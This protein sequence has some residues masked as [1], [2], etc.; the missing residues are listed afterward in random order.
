MVELRIQE[1]Q[2]LLGIGKSGGKAS[3][4]Q[5]I[6]VCSLPDTAVMRNALTLQEKT[7]L[8]IYA[9]TQ[10]VIKLTEEGKLYAV[11]GLPERK[12]GVA[13]IEM[14]GTADLN[15]AAK[16]A[17]LQD[18]FIQIALGWLIRKKWAIYFSQ[19]NTVNIFEEQLQVGTIAEGSDE[20]L[21]K[22]LA[23]NEQTS[24][25]ELTK[26][27]K[28]EA[29]LLKKRK[30]VTIEPKTTRFLQITK[31]GQTAL[32]EG[33]T[34][35]PEIT[36][37][38]PE[39]IITGKWRTAKLQ[40][41]NINAPV[42]KTWPGKKH[43]YLSFLDQVRNKLVT[44]GFQEMTG[45][46]VETCLFNFDALNMPQD[47]PAREASDIYYIKNPKHGNIDNHDAAV[48]N[49][50][51]THENGW[52][53]G[54]TGWG[55]KYSIEVAQRLILRGHSTC[56][57]A[58]TLESK[59]VQIPSKYFSIARVYRPEV[60]DRTHLSEFNQV[61]GIIID[62]NLN[63]K[64]LLG[65]L[66]KFAMEIAGASKV[67]FKPD[68]FPFTE[69]S[70]ELSAYKEGYGWIEFGGSGIF[71]PEVTQPLGIDVPVIAWGLGVDRLFMMR[72]DIDDIRM[73][74]CPSLEWLR[75]KQVT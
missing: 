38:T 42:A 53:T 5:L 75:K 36:Q 71:R 16:K 54:S 26:P 57:S 66:G 32:A 55:Y 29:E 39:I 40:K 22:I 65:V 23:N 44:L 43:P 69:P 35:Q 25:D 8:N 52:Q 10:S 20:A 46:S 49:I 63:L 24:L 19:N 64:D 37:I 70:V 67:R 48:R 45:T 31:E 62:P 73:I 60:V 41:Y 33:N 34:A 51:E 30:L 4:E 3:V 72:Y 7:L 74:F 27:L 58:R 28:N 1:Q 21:L 17:G 56:L 12:L 61:E 59:K 6:S 18:Q 9:A 50:K 14:G 13:I 11:E 15:A 2:I 68:Y 47:H